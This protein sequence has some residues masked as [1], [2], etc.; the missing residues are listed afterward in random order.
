MG[1][2]ERDQQ[3]EAERQRQ[4]LEQQQQQER[5]SSPRDLPVDGD[6]EMINSPVII[7]K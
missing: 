6:P 5:M 4:L 3:A 2:R 7:N 1:T